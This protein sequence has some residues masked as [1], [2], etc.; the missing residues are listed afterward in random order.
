MTLDRTHDAVAPPATGA[1]PANGLRPGGRPRTAIP[2]PPRPR[3]VTSEDVVLGAQPPP[4]PGGPGPVARVTRRWDLAL[5]DRVRAWGWEWPRG[6]DLAVL[7]A[8]V[9]A[10]AALGFWLAVGAGVVAALA[11]ALAVLLLA[12]PAAVVR[13]V[14][15]TAWAQRRAAELGLRLPGPG[16][17]AAGRIDTVVVRRRGALTT[18]RPW[19]VD[20]VV[21]PTG[22]GDGDGS[23]DHVL[24][25][26]ASLGRGLDHPVARAVVDAARDRRLPLPPVEVLAARPGLGVRGVVEGRIVVAG[27]ERFVAGWARRVPERLEAARAA[28]EAAGRGTLL[29]GWEGVVRGVVVL[30]DPARPTAPAAVTALAELGVRTVVASG[31]AKPAATALGDAVG[32]AGVVTHVLPEA[33]GTLVGR[34]RDEGHAVAVTDPAHGPADLVVATTHPVPAD[35]WTAVDTLRLRRLADRVTRQNGVLAVALPVAFV[36]FAAAGALAPPGSALV[37]ALVT[38]VLAANAQRARRY[39]SARPAAHRRS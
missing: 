23:A 1:P 33:T 35:L 36:P 12:V 21:D 7:A 31:E 24:G 34:L 22:A 14:P 18:G 26:A 30:D 17:G 15:V 32:A 20:V 13:A 16:D 2:G 6:A 4:A 27:R 38:G 3:L 9:L 29:V 19:V 25:V 28:A 37:A 10:A 8:A 11:V 5:A 39:A